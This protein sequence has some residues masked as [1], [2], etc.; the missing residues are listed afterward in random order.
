RAA[1]ATTRGATE[2]RAS[3]PVYAAYTGREGLRVRV[4]APQATVCVPVDSWGPACSCS[5]RTASRPDAADRRPVC[6]GPRG[7]RIV[8]V[9]GVWARLARRAGWGLAEVVAGWGG[10]VRGRTVGG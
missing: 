2:S 6:A 1:C 9:G 5:Q 3:S 8:D 4:S 10:A 7:P